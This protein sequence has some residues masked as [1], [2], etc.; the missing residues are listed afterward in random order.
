M[1][2]CLHIYAVTVVT[3][4]LTNGFLDFIEFEN[5]SFFGKRR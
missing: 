2:Q 1:A 5:S 4:L 3:D